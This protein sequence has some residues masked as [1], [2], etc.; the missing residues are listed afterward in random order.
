M[1]KIIYFVILRFCKIMAAVNVHGVCHVY[2]NT[3]E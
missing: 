1:L 3:G 2:K